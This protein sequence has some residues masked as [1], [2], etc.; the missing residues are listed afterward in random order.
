MSCLCA[1]TEANGQRL[2]HFPPVLCSHESSVSTI[3]VICTVAGDP[4]KACVLQTV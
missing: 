4:S 3:Y 2:L 1:I